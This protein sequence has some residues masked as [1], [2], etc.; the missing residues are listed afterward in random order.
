MDKAVSN[1]CNE[2]PELSKRNFRDASCGTMAKGQLFRASALNN[3]SE[4]EK[5]ALS[6][7][8]IRTIIDLRS[9]EEQNNA[10]DTKLP[11]A[12]IV[13]FPIDPMVKRNPFVQFVLLCTGRLFR[14][15]ESMMF[16]LYE[17]VILENNDVLK[18]ILQIL[19]DPENLPAVIHCSAG[20]DRTG[21]LIALI[22]K[23]F[24]A[25]TVSIERDYLRTNDS[26]MESKEMWIRLMRRKS[27]YTLSRTKMDAIFEARTSYLNRMFDTVEKNFGSVELYFDSLLSKSEQKEL[28]KNLQL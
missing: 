1:Q 21:I 9:M 12:Q 2:F 17:R 8:S 13:S 14:D 3:L 10:P 25:D 26:L 19:K 28:R 24:N 27:F 22:Q 4:E 6:D 23:F 16:L 15:P 7:R 20:K 5:L 18:S 11:F